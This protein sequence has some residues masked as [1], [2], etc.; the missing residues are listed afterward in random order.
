MGE[1]RG[2]CVGAGPRVC[3]RGSAAPGAG[4][5]CGGVGAVSVRGRRRR[6][7]RGPAGAGAGGSGSR[8]SGPGRAG[9]LGCFALVS[10]G[11]MSAGGLLGLGVGV[12]ECAAVGAAGPSPCS[13][14]AQGGHRAGRVRAPEGEHGGRWWRLLPLERGGSCSPGA[15]PSLGFG[16]SSLAFAGLPSSQCC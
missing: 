13:E 1:D 2:L 6:R 3:V 4:E 12:A 11:E 16:A 5:G 10:P 14:R 15:L 7:C 8:P 9:G